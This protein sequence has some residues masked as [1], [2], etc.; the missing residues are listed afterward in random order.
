MSRYWQLGSVH[1]IHI[2]LEATSPLGM[3][4]MIL[5]VYIIYHYLSQESTSG[6]AMPPSSVVDTLCLNDCNNHGHCAA[7][8][9]STYGIEG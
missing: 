8:T 5:Y 9:K 6:R 7:G 2:V 4:C 3:G 1:E